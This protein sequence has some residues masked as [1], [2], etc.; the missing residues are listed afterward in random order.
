MRHKVHDQPSF[1]SGNFLFVTLVNLLGPALHTSGLHSAQ[2][3]LRHLNSRMATLVSLSRLSQCRSRLVTRYNPFPG[4]AKCPFPNSTELWAISLPLRVPGCVRSLVSHSIASSSKLRSVALPRVIAST[5]VLTHPL[6]LHDLRA[7][8]E[9]PVILA[10][11]E[12]LGCVMI[13]WER[14]FKCERDAG[15]VVQHKRVDIGI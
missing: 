11:N 13:W 12:G 8:S 7:Y 3:R 6:M 14:E 1:G 2:G 4:R 10:V 9:L 5:R 15:A